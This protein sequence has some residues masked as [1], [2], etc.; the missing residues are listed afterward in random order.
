LLAVIAIADFAFALWMPP[1]AGGIALLVCLYLCFG[2]GNGST[3]QLVPHRWKGK[4]GLLSGM[5]GAAGGIGGFYLPVIMGMAKESTGSYQMGFATFGVLAVF[6]FAFLLAL[7]T[8]WLRWAAP[9]VATLGHGGATAMIH[10]T[11]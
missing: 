6:A 1:V 2:L 3:F 4:T 8:Q 10:A 7:R 5:V 11:E 9:G